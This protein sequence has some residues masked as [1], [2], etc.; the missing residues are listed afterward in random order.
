MSHVIP[1]AE[2]RRYP[3]TQVRMTLSSIR[4]DPDGE[5]IDTLETV[6]ISR[7]GMGAISSIPYY[8]GQ[9]VLVCIPLSTE[10]GQRNIYATVVRCRQVEEGYHVGIEFDSAAPG[11]W[12]EVARSA[13]AAA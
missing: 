10:G 4:L 5:V 13:V 8:P 1:S 9:R 3:R 12:Y 6:D 11:A 2:R 7:R